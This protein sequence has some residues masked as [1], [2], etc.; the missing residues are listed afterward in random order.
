VLVDEAGWIAG[1]LKVFPGLCTINICSEI[2]LQHLLDSC[3]RLVG[4]DCEEAQRQMWL[5]VT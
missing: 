2:T 4:Q 3:A 1:E 5:P